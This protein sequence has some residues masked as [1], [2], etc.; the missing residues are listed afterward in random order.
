MP[1]IKD[2]PNWAG[3]DETLFDQ[4]VTGLDHQANEVA[5]PQAR[6]LQAAGQEMLPRPDGTK[7]QAAHM[8]TVQRTENVDGKTQWAS[9]AQGEYTTLFSKV[10]AVAIH[11][12]ARTD[13]KKEEL[14]SE[15][16]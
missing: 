10:L 9:K 1:R 8:S 15:P 3:V 11:K 16:L 14:Q 13:W 5:D 7:I 12:T 6:Y 2:I 4:C